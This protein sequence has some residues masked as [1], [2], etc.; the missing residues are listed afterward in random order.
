[1]WLHH[2][3]TLVSVYLGPHGGLKSRQWQDLHVVSKS[4]KCGQGELA[5]GGGLIPVE[6]NVCVF[7]ITIVSLLFSSQK[8]SHNTLQNT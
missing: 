3:M 8:Y 2:S 7:L 5:V 6:Y 1:M 4:E